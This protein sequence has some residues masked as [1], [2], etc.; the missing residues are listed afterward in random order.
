[1]LP[2]LMFSMQMR[3]KRRFNYEQMYSSLCRT[4]LSSKDLHPIFYGKSSEKKRSDELLMITGLEIKLNDGMPQMICTTCLNFMNGALR[5]RRTAEKANTKLINAGFRKSVKKQREI[6]SLPVNTNV[7]IRT[8]I[9]DDDKIKT[10]ITENA[11]LDDI[12]NNH[13]Y[14]FDNTYSDD[15]QKNDDHDNSYESPKCKSKKESKEP[16]VYA[17]EV[18]NKEFKMKNTYK[19]HMRFHTNFCVCELCGKK[20][21]NNNLLLLHKRGRHG[22]ERVH[23]C[24][25]CDYSAANKEALIIHERRHTGEKPYICDHCGASF[26]RRSNLV[27]HIAIHLPEKN[28][29]CEQCNKKFHS[30]KFLRSHKFKSH[31]T[32]RYTYVCHLC[33]S[34]FTSTDSARKHL[35]RA[36][37]IPRDAQPP[38]S[39]IPNASIHM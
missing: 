10:D 7:K 21:R 12:S 32:R 34:Q 17:C 16:T 5:F 37:G 9:I 36:H 14:N 39:R 6:S 20:C 18:C 11:L 22:M 1:M 26:H 29:Q 27:Q 38:V 35:T 31:Q 25:Y 3:R 8:I 19:A 30:K 33:G 4:C 23:R 2:V 28:F 15:F 24:A 13:D